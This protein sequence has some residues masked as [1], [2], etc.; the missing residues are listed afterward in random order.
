VLASAKSASIT[1]TIFAA[2][3]AAHGLRAAAGTGGRQGG[4]P[5]V[6]HTREAW[7][8]TSPCCAPLARRRH[9][10]LFHRRH[11]AGAQALDLGFTWLRRRA[12]VSQGRAVREA[13]RIT[14]ADRLLVETDCPY[15][16]PVPHRGKRNEP[17]FVVETA[18]RLA[19]VRGDR[20]EAIAA[21]HHREFRTAAVC[22]AGP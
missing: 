20:M 10:A 14:P 11:R 2:R 12:H 7:D 16:A 5:V 22:G 8:D 18:R 4:K 17:A 21:A 19:E 15:L 1:I 9:H 3:R 6:I 13:A